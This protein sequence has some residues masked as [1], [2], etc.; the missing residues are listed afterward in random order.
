MTYPSKYSYIDIARALC[1]ALK[2]AAG[3]LR[4]DRFIRAERLQVH[5]M[6]HAERTQLA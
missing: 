5:Q 2:V 4:S 1:R 6:E 3:A